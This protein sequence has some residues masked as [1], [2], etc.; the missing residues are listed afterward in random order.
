MYAHHARCEYLA[1]PLEGHL[2]IVSKEPCR[3]N[4]HFGTVSKPKKSKYFSSQKVRANVVTVDHNGTKVV[5]CSFQFASMLHCVRSW[6]YC[7][8]KSKHPNELSYK[9][10]ALQNASKG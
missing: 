9:I 6:R 8:T 1:S 7:C 3:T 2:S 10:E 4:M 5:E